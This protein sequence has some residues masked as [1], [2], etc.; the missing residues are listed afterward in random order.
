MRR[1]NTKIVSI[2]WLKDNLNHPNLIILDASLKNKPT[3]TL[4]ITDLQ[5]PKT[6][7]FD[8]KKVFSD[9]NSRFPNML[10]SSAQF[11]R[12]A[13]NLGINTDSLIVIYDKQGIYTSPRVWWMFKTMGH[14]RVAVLDGGLPAW[15]NAGFETENT[16]A[17]HYSKGDFEAKFDIKQ[18]KD[19]DFVRT[20]IDENKVKIIDAR[21]SGRFNGTAPEPRKGLPSGNIPNSLNLPFTEVLSDGHFKSKEDL[22]I[23]FGGL[24]TENQPLVF[25]CG[26]G[27][28]AC[29]LYLASE[30]VHENSSQKAIYDGS[31]TEWATVMRE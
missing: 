22:T 31:W 14:G 21:S 4:E 12:E 16:Q 13:Q 8:I 5:I 25:S 28:T 2:D 23:I 24:P 18:V 30:I 20:N 27:I 29:I 6:R 3:K 19:I 10:P 7:Y 1:M 26:S 11:E 9:Q 15:Y 17:H